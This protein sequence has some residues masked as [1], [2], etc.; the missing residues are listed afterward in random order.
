MQYIE[1]DHAESCGAQTEDEESS[2]YL[3]AARGRVIALSVCQSVSGH[4]NEH[5]EQ[6]RNAC[7]FFLQCISNK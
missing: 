6:I 4:I 5:I 7:S 1:L 2:R 3:C